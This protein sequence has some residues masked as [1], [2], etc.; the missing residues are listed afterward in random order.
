M[1]LEITY[2]K[3]RDLFYKGLKDLGFDFKP[4][5]GTYFM[6]VPIDS[7]TKKN[8]IEFAKELIEN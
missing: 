1:S 7:F 3:K 5:S 6:L 4:P 8:D 2:L